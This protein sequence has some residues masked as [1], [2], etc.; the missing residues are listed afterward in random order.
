MLFK[1]SV[2]SVISFTILVKCLSGDGLLDRIINPCN[3]PNCF[4]S[5][6]YFILSSDVKSDF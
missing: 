6:S 2:F 3:I 5:S 4:N 1:I